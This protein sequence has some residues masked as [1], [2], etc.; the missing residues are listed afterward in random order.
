M[1]NFAPYNLSNKVY[2]CCRGL[3]DNI[4]NVFREVW[5]EFDSL[6]MLRALLLLLL[7]IFFNWLV[8]EG[9]PM[10]RLPHVFAS[11]FVP[12]GL[13]S[14]ALCIS[15]CYTAYYF[16]YLEDL[17]H[18][19]I[20]STGLI[21][22]ALTCVLVLM[23]W[24]GITQRWC[25]GRSQFYERFAR[26]ALVASASVLVSNSYIIEEG[27]GLSFLSL[28][29]LALM[30]WNVGN[31]KASVIWVGCGISLAVSRLYRGCREE[32]GDCWTAGTGVP[33]GQ[34]SRAALVLALGSVAA[35]VAVA[36]RYIGWRGYGIVVAGLFAC[37][38]W[39]V[40]WGSLGSPSRSRLLARGSWL[41][42]ALMFAMLWRR[43]GRGA[44]LPLMVCSLLFY[45]GNSLVLGAAY[46]PSAAIML[47]L[48]FLALN[49]VSMLKNE[50][51]TKFCKYFI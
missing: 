5:V 51:S 31:V 12:S 6:S 24:D 36:R 47:V 30:A 1:S 19:I 28:S 41:V 34:A 26:G 40:G 10:E 37:A 48:G 49:I 9:L 32:Q 39:A 7:A 18:A 2:F 29:V 27:A 4:R 44:T 23:H 3:I 15:V 42:L 46:A 8:T 45:I 35:V 20:L 22:G 38:H 50:G 21:S 33:S 11:T 13:I 14:M 17:E 16:K 25:E 43:E